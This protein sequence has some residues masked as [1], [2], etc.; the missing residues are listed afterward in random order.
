[1]VLFGGVGHFAVL[2]VADAAA[3]LP[4]VG[5]G[6]NQAFHGFSAVNQP[7]VC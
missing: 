2:C 4:F 6:K 5:S 7:F 1:M 3:L